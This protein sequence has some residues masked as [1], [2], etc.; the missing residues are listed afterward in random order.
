MHMDE[1]IKVLFLPEPRIPLFSVFSKT[2]KG[3]RLKRKYDTAIRELGF[4]SDDYIGLIGKEFA[5]MDD[6]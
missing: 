5:R 6:K 4:T 3:K 2:E 1:Q